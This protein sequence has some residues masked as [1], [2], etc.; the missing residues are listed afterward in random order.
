MLGGSDEE[1]LGIVRQLQQMDFVLAEYLVEYERC[2]LG[3]SRV[4]LAFDADD[5]RREGLVAYHGLEEL[6]NPAH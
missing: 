6:L 2:C 4:Q 5:C 1:N 3:R